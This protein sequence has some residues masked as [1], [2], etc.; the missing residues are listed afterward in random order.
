MGVDERAQ[1]VLTPTG[2]RVQP[3]V[4]AGVER[5]GLWVVVIDVVMY[6]VVAVIS[7]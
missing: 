2:Y 4:P 7:E 1:D 3:Y 6:I 5:L